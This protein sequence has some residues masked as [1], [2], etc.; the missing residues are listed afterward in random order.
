MSA[1]KLKAIV[2]PFESDRRI[3][4]ISELLRV[5]AGLDPQSSL[6]KVLVGYQPYLDFCEYQHAKS[7]SLVF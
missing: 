5:P 1:N 4:A 3:S 2:W 7:H 6:L